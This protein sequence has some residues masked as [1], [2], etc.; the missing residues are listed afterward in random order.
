MFT[1]IIEEI[2]QLKTIHHGANS[3]RLT[4]EAAKVLTDTKIGDSIATNGVC[5]TITTKDATAFSVDVMHETL[6]R[7]N[8]GQL[9]LGSKLNLERAMPA[10]ARFDGHIVSG[11]IDGTG[12]IRSLK[13]DDI[14]IWVV[15]E[16]GPELLKY[17]VEKGSIAVDGISL[18]VATVDASSFSIS[19]IP[20]TKEET[21]LTKK[22]PGDR[23]NLE[24]D[25]IAKYVEKL[26]KKETP[27]TETG[28]DEA[29]LRK[30]GY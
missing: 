12:R 8:L 23:V 4:I 15:I 28:I 19:I 18:T 29:F 9:R 5:L 24:V 26:L 17:I 20:H 25:I 1:G 14:A 22:K 13:E 11:H 27:K 7:S 3:A 6:K 2:G 21:T 10:T 30:Y 16:A